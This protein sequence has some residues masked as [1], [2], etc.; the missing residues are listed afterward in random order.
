MIKL[1]EELD[2]HLETSRFQGK[3]KHIARARKRGK[4][5]ARERIEL[6]LD[7]DS[8]FLELIAFGRNATAKEALEQEVQ[9]YAG[10]G[11]VQGKLCMISSN[12]GT[13]KGGSVDCANRF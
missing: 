8:P 9:M 4:L 2:K 12:V 5:L 1:V 3:D 7:K 13:R 6:L 11:L 10:I